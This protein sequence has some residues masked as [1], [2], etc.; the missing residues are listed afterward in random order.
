MGISDST[1]DNTTGT[2]EE[3]I[4]SN[5]PTGFENAKNIMADKMHHVAEAINEKA[6][7]QDPL[8]DI[9]QYG[10]QASEW[11]DQSAEYVRRFNFEHADAKIREYVRQSPGRSLLLAGAAGM[12]IGAILRCR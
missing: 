9:T 3:I 7:D 1:A 12:M 2:A 11:L 8:C 5:K 4:G 6:A 10:K